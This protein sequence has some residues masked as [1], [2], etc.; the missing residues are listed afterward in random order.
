MQDNR[1]NYNFQ[2]LL[3]EKKKLAD[4]YCCSLSLRKYFSQV[5]LS[6]PTLGHYS[7][8]STHLP[9]TSSPH[10]LNYS[11]ASLPLGY[12]LG[13]LRCSLHLVIHLRLRR[14]LPLFAR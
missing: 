5:V 11:T 9:Y 14:S 3:L 7:T 13:A 12:C 1:K 8:A 2:F 6:V 4:V 10:P